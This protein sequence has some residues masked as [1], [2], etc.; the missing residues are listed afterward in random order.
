MSEFID[1]SPGMVEGA[2]GLPR[3]RGHPEADAGT[4]R[5][6]QGPWGRPWAPSQTPRVMFDQISGFPVVQS[7]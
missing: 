4:G 3:Q 5:A 1:I 7:R 6:E 2:G